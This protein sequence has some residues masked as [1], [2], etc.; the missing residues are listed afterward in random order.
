MVRETKLHQAII[1]ETLESV[2]P[3]PD[4]APQDLH[5]AMRYGV[6]SGG[7]RLRPLLVLAAAEAVSGAA[8]TDAKTAA[9]AIELLHTYTLIHDDLPAMDDDKLRRG[10]PTVH[11]KFGEAQ[12]ILAGDGLLTLCFEVLSNTTIAPK[13]IAE[14][15][16]AAGSRGVVGGQWVDIV[17]EG[18]TLT[19]N[20]IQYINEHKTA[21]LLQ[22][23]VRMGALCANATATQLKELTIYGNCIGHAFQLIDDLLDADEETD[24]PT[25]VAVYGKAGTE[26]RV[27]EYIERAQASLKEIPH[28][29]VLSEIAAF[30]GS[31]TA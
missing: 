27:T 10:K 8:T 21:Q 19:E 15:A 1:E 30:I 9:A 26:A 18:Q 11:V 16:A 2:L 24:K 7:K 4:E 28:P 20:T 13:L 6:F 29:E 22:A 3:L 25:S 5:A 23:A 31:R 17:S 14:L 12:A